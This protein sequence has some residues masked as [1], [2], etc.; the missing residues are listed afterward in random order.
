MNIFYIY[1]HY[2]HVIVD[3][4]LKQ[5]L[6]ISSNILYSVMYNIHIFNFYVL[7]LVINLPVILWENP[8]KI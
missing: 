6:S 2:S 1:S 7:Y 3:N 4:L 5:E 8:Q